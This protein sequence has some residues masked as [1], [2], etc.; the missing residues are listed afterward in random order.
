MT[1]PIWFVKTRL[2]LDGQNI[3]AWECI[4]R[5][6][7]K[8]VNKVYY[9]TNIIY[10]TVCMCVFVGKNNTEIDYGCG[11]WNIPNKTLKLVPI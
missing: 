8:T 1:N 3:T 9:R 2:Q 5:I 7:T 10:V 4:K 6:Y 11:P